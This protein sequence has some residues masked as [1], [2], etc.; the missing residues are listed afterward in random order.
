MSMSETDAVCLVLADDVARG[1]LAPERLA[2]LA[3]TVATEPLRV[4]LREAAGHLAGG[5]G[6]SEALGRVGVIPEAYVLAVGAGEPGL[7]RAMAEAASAERRYLAAARRA[8]ARAAG[9]LAAVLVAV[10]LGAHLGYPR[11]E[12]VVT[13]TEGTLSGLVEASIAGLRW[14]A[15]PIGLVLLALATLAAQRQPRWLVWMPRAAWLDAPRAAALRGLAALIEAGMSVER[16]LHA[17]SGAVTDTGLRGALRRAA[18]RIEQGAPPS[19]ALEDPALTG[20]LAWS[21]R[22]NDDPAAVGVTA[23]AAAD[24]FA[25]RALVSEARLE[26]RARATYAIVGG[27][28]VLWAGLTLAATMWEVARCLA[29]V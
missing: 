21:W 2:A 15:G 11:L 18:Q 3:E 20:D 5:V 22:R 26:T 4:G 17:V 14:L 16:A 1:G 27:A 12:A 8:A 13:E 9:L 7:V 10:A 19:D 6:L 24:V 25:A 23:A 28:L 29:F